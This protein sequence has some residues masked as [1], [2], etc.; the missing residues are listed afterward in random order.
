[1][2]WFLRKYTCECLIQDSSCS[3]T[4]R[5]VN[6]PGLPGMRDLCA[7]TG[8]GPN[9][10]GGADHAIHTQLCS[11]GGFLPQPLQRKGRCCHTSYQVNLF[12]ILA[13]A[14]ISLF[15]P[16]PISSQQLPVLL[17]RFLPP[18]LTSGLFYAI[19]LF[20]WKNS[21]CSCRVFLNQWSQWTSEKERDFD[22]DNVER[23]RQ[24]DLRLGCLSWSSQ[25]CIID[26][27]PTVKSSC[28]NLGSQWHFLWQAQIENS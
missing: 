25:K 12:E 6:S 16:L 10:G 8:K 19:W 23:H 13:H 20:F 22:I 3:Y 28:R 1:M 7:R 2:N 5:V 17:S 14:F 4:L 26:L 15:L 9:K 27:G 24:W 11:P 18:S 21:H